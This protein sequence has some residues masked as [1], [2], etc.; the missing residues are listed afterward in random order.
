MSIVI[1]GGQARNVGKTSVVCALIAAMPE[2]R[3][4][5]VKITQFGHGVCSA[6]GEPCDCE[7]ADHT[8]AISQESDACTGSVANKNIDCRH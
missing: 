2:R 5:A 4:T 8:L 7:T 3:W 1:I 6:N